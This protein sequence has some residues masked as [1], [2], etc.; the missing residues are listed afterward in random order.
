QSEAHRYRRATNDNPGR[1]IGYALH[2]LGV[3][4]EFVVMRPIHWLVSRDYLDVVFGHAAH[5]TD[6]GTYF[7]WSHGDFRPSVA[8]ERSA[9]RK[10]RA[11]NNLSQVEA[12]RGMEM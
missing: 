11:E 5:V 7:E 10:W 3:A 6:D 12:R 2:P 4:A 8:E 1:L 9:F